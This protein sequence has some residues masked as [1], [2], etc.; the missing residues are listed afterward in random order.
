[1]GYCYKL[2]RVASEHERNLRIL[3]EMI[4]LIGNRVTIFMNC[5]KQY[6]M[7]FHHQGLKDYRF[8]LREQARSVQYIGSHFVHNLS[9]NN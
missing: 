6:N 2:D 3:M 7:I 1:M 4:W 9:K 8:R 5:E